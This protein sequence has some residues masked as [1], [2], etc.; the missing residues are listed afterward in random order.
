M[1]VCGQYVWVSAVSV[2]V[3][4]RSVCVGVCGQ[5]ACVSAVGVCVCLRSMC[6]FALRKQENPVMDPR[7]RGSIILTRPKDSRRYTGSLTN[8]Q[9]PRLPIPSP[10]LNYRMLIKKAT[11]NGSAVPWI[12]FPHRDH[13]HPGKFSQ[14]RRYSPPPHFPGPPTLHLP[15]FLPSPL[16][17]IY[18]HPTLLEAS[19]VQKDVCCEE[20]RIV[21]AIQGAAGTC[22]TNPSCSPTSVCVCVCVSGW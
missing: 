17:A 12:H 18:L 2:Y 1:C 3:C 16:P 4:L 20:S 15:F 19:S 10:S 22:C 6:T 8:S 21:D 13:E 11:D 14:Q 5:C 7:R 9:W